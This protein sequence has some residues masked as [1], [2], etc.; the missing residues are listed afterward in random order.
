MERPA[1]R[2]LEE[3]VI[4]VIFLLFLLRGG[5]G[6]DAHASRQKKRWRCIKAHHQQ[7]YSAKYQMSRRLCVPWLRDPPTIGH[8]T[9]LVWEHSEKDTI[10]SCRGYIERVWFEKIQR[11]AWVA[12][13]RRNVYSRCNLR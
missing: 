10:G 11:V 2:L 5:S 12:T 13:E 1:S 9:R 7:A 8:E 3:P 6:R 4:G